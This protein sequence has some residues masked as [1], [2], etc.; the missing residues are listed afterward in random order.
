M[1]RAACLVAVASLAGSGCAGPIGGEW[2]SASV[3]QG[4]DGGMHQNRLTIGSDGT[5][6]AVIHFFFTDD[7]AQAGHTDQFEVAWTAVTDTQF[8]LDLVCFD[9]DGTAACSD[10]DFTMTCDLESP[11][12][13]VLV[14]SGDKIWTDYPFQW[15]RVVDT[16]E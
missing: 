10:E 9:F 16:A 12:A 7:P 8:E 6:L 11:E 13:D 1:R 2:L 15:D 14:C 4:A 3:T 5:G